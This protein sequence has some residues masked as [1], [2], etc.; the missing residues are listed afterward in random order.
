M[1]HAPPIVRDKMKA[2]EIKA[3]HIKRVNKI[4][5]FVE[6][7]L[8]KELSLKSLSEMANYSP[9]HFHRIFLQ[10]TK[11]TLNSFIVRKRI[12]KIAAILTVG[13]EES[14][15]DLAFKYG[16]SSGNAFSRA[17]R[18]FYDVNPSEFKDKFSKI[19]VEV[20]DYDKYI[21][22]IKNKEEKT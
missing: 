14:L 3:D 4:M 9:Y 1:F 5:D 19:G 15:S 17:F 13:T 10:V 22:K 6:R 21:C 12:E 7:N 8:D 2:R 20:L 11:E 16:F 18:K